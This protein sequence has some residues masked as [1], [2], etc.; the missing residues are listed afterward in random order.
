MIL[1]NFLFISF[2]LLISNVFA[3]QASLTPA[4]EFVLKIAEPSGLVYDNLNG[5]L[6]TH[7]DGLNAN[8]YQISNRGIVLDSLIIGG[9][10]FEGI[11]FNAGFDTIFTVEEFASRISKY[12]LEGTLVDFI[13]VDIEP[14]LSGLEGITVNPENGHIFVVKEKSPILLELSANGS[15][16]FRDTLAFLGSGDASGIAIHPAWNTL[17]VLS[18]ENKAVYETTLSGKYLRSWSIPV[19]KAEGITFNTAMDSIYIVDDLYNILYVFSFKE[20]RYIHNLYINEIMAGNSHSLQDNNG[21]FDDWIELYNP[22]D[23]SVDIGG[24]SIA[25]NFIRSGLWQIP[26]GFSSQTTIPA[27]GYIVLWADEEVSQGPLHINFKLNKSGEQVALYNDLLLL[28]S[29]SF[30]PQTDDISY[31]R[32]NDGGAPWEFFNPGSPNEDNANGVIVS[33]VKEISPVTVNTFQLDQNFPNPFNPLTMIKY[34]LT[35]SGFVTLKVFDITGR[36][37]QILVNRKQNAGNYSVPF[38]G[39][40]LPSG[41]YFYTLQTGNFSSTKKMILLK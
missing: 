35:M 7:N 33:G 9:Q 36:E 13:N 6:Y 1:K 15:E 25:D 38:D 31:G 18:H 10:D 4:H 12:S 20:K 30:P 21:D 27:K 39:K 22:N 41:I 17:F 3:F 11:S 34:Q 40:H 16:L 14:G 2:L 32:E 29:L 8:I 23:F 24:L 26:K 37:I 5:T 19:E 28:D